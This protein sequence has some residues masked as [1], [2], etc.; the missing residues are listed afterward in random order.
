M[1]ASPSA[2]VRAAR[3]GAPAKD[4]V[5][6]AAMVEGHVAAVDDVLGACA[7]E[8]GGATCAA[9]TCWIPTP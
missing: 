9:T 7:P 3:R 8:A 5:V 1:L 6:D 4:R 2:R